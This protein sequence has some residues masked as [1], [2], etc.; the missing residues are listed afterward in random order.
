L[1]DGFAP[2]ARGSVG[3][4]RLSPGH[5]PRLFALHCFPDRRREATGSAYDD[6]G[7]GY[8]EHRVDQFEL[9]D[10]SRDSAVLHWERTGDYRP[11]DDVA[12]VVHGLTVGRVLADGEEVGHAVTSQPGGA[13]STSIRCGPFTALVFEDLDPP[14]PD[15]P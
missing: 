11:P 6:A 4:A 10:Q 8:A 3:F 15:G 13:T 5:E 7:D 14:F 9:R 1:D 12:V 2:S